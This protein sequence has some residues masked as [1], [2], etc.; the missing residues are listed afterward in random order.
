MPSSSCLPLL[1]SSV[2]LA[3]CIFIKTIKRKAKHSVTCA[4]GKGQQFE[5]RIKLETRKRQ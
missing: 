2:E 5:I 3:W 4:N 1:E